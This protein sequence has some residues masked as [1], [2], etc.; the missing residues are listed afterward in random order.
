MREPNVCAR[1]TA[2]PAAAGDVDD[3]GVGVKP[4]V[5]AEATDLLGARRILDGVV[6]LGDR[7]EPGTVELPPAPR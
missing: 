6:A 7:E 4:E 2:G 1:I 5:L 3:T